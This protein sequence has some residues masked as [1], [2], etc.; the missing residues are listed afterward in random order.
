M[1]KNE[2]YWALDADSFNKEI[3]KMFRYSCLK[4]V[5]AFHPDPG[6]K[7]KINVNF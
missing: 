6:Q 1:I 7:E 4:N 5:D 2:I 3:I